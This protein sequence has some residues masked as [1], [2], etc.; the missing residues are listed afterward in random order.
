MIAYFEIECPHTAPEDVVLLVGSHAVIGN[1]DIHRAV[2]LETSP[3]RFPWW[4]TA[5]PLTID[6]A[7]VEFQFA[8][9]D[10]DFS[11]PV[12]WE[13]VP[14]PRRVKRAPQRKDGLIMEVVFRASWDDAKSTVTLRPSMV[15]VRPRA[16]YPVPPDETSRA[17][18]LGQTERSRSR[19]EPRD[20]QTRREGGQDE[21]LGWQIEDPT[22]VQMAGT[23]K[24]QG[25]A[26]QSMAGPYDRRGA[27]SGPAQA[28]S[29]LQT[30]STGGSSSSRAVGPC[31]AG[32]G[33]ANPKGL[34]KSESPWADRPMQTDP[35]MGGSSRFE[36]GGDGSYGGRGVLPDQQLEE[37]PPAAP[38]GAFRGGE[39][40]RGGH[41]QSEVQ[42]QRAPIA[43]SQATFSSAS[44]AATTSQIHRSS[45]PDGMASQQA[46]LSSSTSL[47]RK[48]ESSLD[49]IRGAVIRTFKDLTGFNAEV[50]EE[51]A[52]ICA[53]TASGPVAAKLSDTSTLTN[54]PIR[55][56]ATEDVQVSAERTTAGTNLI[57]SKGRSDGQASP[58]LGK[59]EV[60]T[61]IN[62]AGSRD[63]R[64]SI[65]GPTQKV[66][67][68]GNTSPG[69]L[70]RSSP[71]IEGQTGIS[72]TKPIESVG[73]HSASQ[74]ELVRRPNRQSP[75]SAQQSSG[76]EGSGRRRRDAK[77]PGPG[78]SLS[79]SPAG[80]PGTPGSQGS[81]AKPRVRVPVRRT[82]VDT[83]TVRQTNRA[84]DGA[85]SPAVDVVF[86]NFVETNPTASSSS[87]SSPSVE[88]GRSGRQI[89]SVGRHSVHFRDAPGRRQARQS[90]DTQS[91]EGPVASRVVSRPEGKPVK[92]IEGSPRHGKAAA[93]HTSGSPC[94]AGTANSNAQVSRS[95]EGVQG[96][97]A[98]PANVKHLT[99]LA[100]DE[101]LKGCHATILEDAA[102]CGSF[103]DE[104]PCPTEGPVC[105][106]S[107]RVAC[108]PVVCVGT[109]GLK[110]PGYREYARDS[111]E[112]QVIGYH[113]AVDQA[114]RQDGPSREEEPMFRS[115]D[116]GKSFWAEASN[117]ELENCDLPVVLVCSEL[118]P[119]SNSGGM[120]RISASLS[121]QIA[122]RGH[123][124]MSVAPMYTRPPPE[125]G[126]MYIGSAWIRL[127]QRDQEVR[128]M[129]KFISFGNGKGCDYVLLDHGCYQHRPH[130]LYCDYR[131][132]QDYGDNLYRFAML[133]LAALEIP[134]RLSFGGAPYGQ[135]VIFF[136]SDWQAGLLPVYLAHRYRR[137]GVYREAR[138][139]HIIHNLGYQ[140]TFSRAGSNAH[141]LLG[142]GELATLD[143][144]K[145]ADLNLC[146]GA[147]LCA[148]RVLT[149]SPSYAAEV[150]TPEGG[151]GLDDILSQKYNM[152]RFHGIRNAIDDEWDPGMD[153]H[154]ARKYG[155]D[156]FI[157]ARR[158]CKAAL[159]KKLGLVITPNAVVFG[160]VGRLTWQ[161]GVDV[162]T[163]ALSWLLG[164]GL[165]GFPGRAQV[166]LMGE[167]E[168]QYQHLV[169][170]L[171][172]RHRGAVC[173]Y[174]GFDPILE[175][176]MMAGCDFILMPSRYEPCGLPQMAAA[177][178]GAVVI[179]TATGGLKDCVKGIEEQDA[180]GFLIHPPVTEF[181]VRQALREA[182][183]L[184]FHNPGRFQQLQ[185]NAMSR[186]FRW[187]PSLD[188]YEH[189]IR[190]A[191]VSPPQKQ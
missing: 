188:E 22:L 26:G 12:R 131:T 9:V 171:E 114:I 16:G 173:G 168:Q 69:V 60:V 46:T 101:N 170:D 51:P 100:C 108:A 161:K 137:T 6:A 145:D 124:T 55:G 87:R 3:Q 18:A 94:Q 61:V 14:F 128:C 156:N 179:A 150:L 175:H 103:G 97:E 113:K 141:S 17:R 63:I 139:I 45:L 11:R 78:T 95:S 167:G 149:V 5:A 8:I 2:R 83:T 28:L 142:L 76:T 159:Q 176:Q 110:H 33:Q 182:S 169:H 53:N 165:Q 59:R 127:D 90:N 189:Q 116:V 13:S 132:G 109:A 153:V 184:Y 89:E 119:W 135:R 157:S 80:S 41:A 151:F 37:P 136:S 134:L 92:S 130:G 166:V 84:S 4:F 36:Q 158:E 32:K 125:D 62:Q 102:H 50:T 49:A 143:L 115:S 85:S 117:S 160:F 47:P 187:G 10:S 21:L 118:S 72:K 98:T 190:L 163:R 38:L 25:P 70:R 126:F 154:I 23:G 40:V 34:G 111:C 68:R 7:E 164:N 172:M 96:A 77:Q 148:D 48:R 44:T 162:L 88:F 105:F 183:A 155:L 99:A 19:A 75:D 177:L 129:H 104:A 185:R 178:Y 144:N 93:P 20:A 43:E 133:S 31:G 1:W 181:G 65:S 56:D 66:I 138:S 106:G 121:Q 191:V 27:Y 180:T 54:P 86:E 71:S 79:K 57:E 42:Q 186:S 122:L 64:K 35:V 112:S 24:R 29:A 147:I 52:S 152:H 30:A 15:A 82:P 81:A 123:R 91:S 74:R 73:R 58:S 120:G 146:K 39:V 107:E 67:V 140:G 174:T